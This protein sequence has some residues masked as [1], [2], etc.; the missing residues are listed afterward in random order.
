MG[1]NQKLT[2]EVRPTLD[3]L[4]RHGLVV[5]THNGAGA[6]VYELTEE[7]EQFFSRRDRE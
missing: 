7:G 3:F 2:N 6:Q 1:K 4:V 5:R